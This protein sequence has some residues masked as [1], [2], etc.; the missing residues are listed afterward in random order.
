MVEYGQFRPDSTL[1]LM[2]TTSGP[3]YGI[4]VPDTPLPYCHVIFTTPADDRLT[5]R[6][7]GAPYGESTPKFSEDITIAY[8]F[9]HVEAKTT[10]A[11]TWRLGALRQLVDE[12]KAEPDRIVEVCEGL[13]DLIRIEADAV[14][15]GWTMAHTDG[16]TSTPTLCLPF[17]REWYV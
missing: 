14:R 11:A 2:P 5:V 6:I 3:I 1:S 12:F 9:D 13:P 4:S 16:R 7:T 10:F 17:A 15:I 8:S